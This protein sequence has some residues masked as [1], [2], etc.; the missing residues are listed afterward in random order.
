MNTTIRMQPKFLW[1]LMLSYSMVLLMANWFDARLIS[2]FHLTTD[3]GTLIFP[4][5]FLLADVIT[6]VYGFK[7]TRCAI[8]A[9]FFFNLLFLGYGQMV[10]HMPSPDFYHN[11]VYFDHVLTLNVR[12]VLASLLSYL[13][14]EPFNAFAI[15]KLKVLCKGR[16]MALRFVG[17]TMVAAL[18]DS[19]FF[20]LIAF[21]GSMP[22]SELITLITT[23]W[24]IKVV[25]EII[26]LPFSVWLANKL[27]RI[28]QMD[29]YDYDTDF[30][31]L[32]TSI[33][34]RQEN[35]LADR[36]T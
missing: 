4:I 34:Y 16:Y 17:S 14:A 22:G 7:N 24:L 8:W 25:I 31:L 36:L 21:T 28:E 23:M 33:S 3:A 10:A 30:T 15:A 12:I 19:V 1:F 13:I 9:G 27:K 5:T 11:N 32:K 6:E 18:F 2:V 35:N 20:S 29:I 26:G